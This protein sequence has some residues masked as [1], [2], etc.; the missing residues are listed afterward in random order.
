MFHL[1]PRVRRHEINQPNKVLAR[2]VYL[3]FYYV[4]IE[5]HRCL[6]FKTARH[7]ISDG[8]MKFLSNAKRVIV[9][10][11]YQNGDHEAAWL[12]SGCWLVNVSV[13]CLWSNFI[14]NQGL[15][16]DLRSRWRFGIRL[17]PPPPPPP[18]PPAPHFP[19]P[20]PPLQLHLPDSPVLSFV[21]PVISDA[22]P[23]TTF[24]STSAPSSIVSHELAGPFF[25]F[26]LVL[27][28]L[29]HLA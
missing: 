2:C 14:S 28:H 29:L 27:D 13:R 9:K 22:F 18:Q 26:R 7:C 11:D 24:I 6:I 3:C 12:E 17:D 16:Q 5:V 1:F 10:A 15:Q 25:W 8:V 21:G 4:A 20:H 23:L 19:P